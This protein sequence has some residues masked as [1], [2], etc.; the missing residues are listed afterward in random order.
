MNPETWVLCKKKTKRSKDRSQTENIYI[1]NCIIIF[2]GVMQWVVSTTAW[3][4]YN[5]K[6]GGLRSQNKEIL[7]QEVEGDQV[8][9]LNQEVLVHET[10][11]W[12]RE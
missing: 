1:K 9:S 3:S 2:Q 12:A 6:T 11:T 10:E 5:Y 7:D 8:Q 4:Y